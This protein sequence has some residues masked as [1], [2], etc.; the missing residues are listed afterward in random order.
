[1]N[2]KLIPL[3]ERKSIA[4]LLGAGFSAPKGYPIGE[5]IN[6][7]LLNFN[8]STLDFSPAGKLAKID[9]K[10]PKFQI[11]RV[12]NNHQKYFVFC[13]R[14]IKEYT[15]TH[16][17]KFDYE[18]FYDFIKTNEA[19]DNRYKKLCDDLYENNE[20]YGNYLFNVPHIY[21]QMVAHLIKDKTGKSWYDDESFSVS[22]E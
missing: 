5:A 11:D 1:M 4:F 3:S 18:K 15:I 17:N 9:N 10:T 6:K 22:L 19:M 21:N 16:N 7:R 14:L 13:K 8:D 2:N 12:L 20:T